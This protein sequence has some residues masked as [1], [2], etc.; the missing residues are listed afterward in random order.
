MFVSEFFKG[1][2][3][4]G[5]CER[6]GLLSWVTVISNSLPSK[7]KVGGLVNIVLHTIFTCNRISAAQSNRL[8]LQNIST[9]QVDRKPEM[10]EQP[11]QLEQAEINSEFEAAI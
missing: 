4:C 9:E 3:G 11:E 1:C 6:S 8:V 7:R 2:H 10:P 5:S